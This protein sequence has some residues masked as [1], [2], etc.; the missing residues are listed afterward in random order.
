VRGGHAAG[1]QRFAAQAVGTLVGAFAGL[2]SQASSVP[3]IA[4]AMVERA[5][6]G[7]GVT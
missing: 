6:G 4:G 5:L 2:R 7:A 3:G 1:A